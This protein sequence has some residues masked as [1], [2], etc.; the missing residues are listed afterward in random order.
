MV[1]RY[2]GAL[3][4]VSVQHTHNHPHNQ[5]DVGWVWWPMVVLGCLMR[6]IFQVR[7][8][9]SIKINMGTV[10]QYGIGEGEVFSILNL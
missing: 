4:H 9:F 6:A 8:I 7:H 1:C 2:L 5:R 10:Q 3:V